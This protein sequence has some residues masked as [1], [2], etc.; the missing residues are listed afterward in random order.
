MSG[1]YLLALVAI[2]SFLSWGIYR[3]WRFWK[4]SSLG[5]KSV[6]IVIG[7]VLLSSW[8]GWTVWEVAGKKMYWD[9]KVR[10]LCAKDGGIDVYEKVE[11]PADVYEQYVNENWILPD[12]TD[13]EPKDEYYVEWKLFYYHKGNPQVSRSET[14]IVRRSDG[15]IL[16]KYISYGRGGGDLPGPWNGSSFTCPNP[17]HLQNFETSVFKKG[18]KK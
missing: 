7:L 13:V 4:P 11:L 17:A 1:F 15:K 10:E 14:R 3:I 16:G 6:H 9:A 18:G 2:W 12:K 8:F 5:K